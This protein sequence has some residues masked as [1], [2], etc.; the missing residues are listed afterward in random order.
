MDDKTVKR[1]PI[2]QFSSRKI[3]PDNKRLLFL[4]IGLENWLISILNEKTH[5]THLDKSKNMFKLK[6]MEWILK[7]KLEKKAVRVP[8]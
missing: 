7:K 8:F 4:K 6:A 5:K 2:K 1:F 3:Y